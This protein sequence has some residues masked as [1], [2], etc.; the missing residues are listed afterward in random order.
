VPETMER[1]I[2]ITAPHFCACVVV[3]DG[4]VTETA[5]I[6]WYMTGWEELRVLGYVL[7]R[8]AKW[9]YHIIEM[10]DA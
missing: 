6:L 1:L 4:K 2:R 3:R 8:S 10:G 5:P 7:R 9:R